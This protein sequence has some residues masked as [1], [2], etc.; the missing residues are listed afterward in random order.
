MTVSIAEQLKGLLAQE[1]WDEAVTA[2]QQA[3]PAVTAQVFAALPFEQ[4]HQLFVHLLVPFA[5][6]LLAQF[7]YYQQYV[8]LHSRPRDLQ[9]IVDAMNPD[10][11]LR[12]AVKF[13]AEAVTRQDRVRNYLES[14][15]KYRA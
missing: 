9:A 7:P 15:P 14:N 4:Q 10:D 2:S 8:L 11:R 12:L 3:G 6:S 13:L 5:A 1:H